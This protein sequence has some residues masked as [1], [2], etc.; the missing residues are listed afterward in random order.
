METT[1]TT[2]MK[3]IMKQIECITGYNLETGQQRKI[4]K[5]KFESP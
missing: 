4:T 5:L 2:E 1:E 3:E